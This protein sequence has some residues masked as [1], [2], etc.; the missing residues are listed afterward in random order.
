MLR[1]A[2]GSQRSGRVEVCF[3]GRWG[4]ICD[5]SWDSADAKTVCR[6]LKLPFKDAIGLRGAFFG[7]GSG[8][9]FLDD[10][11]CTTGN[12]TQFSECFKKGDIGKHNCRHSQDVSVVCPGQ[13][14]M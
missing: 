1:L 10:V 4:T 12:E 6:Q 11:N 5:D 9:I 3:N 2:G 14:L 13:K 8:P 7:K